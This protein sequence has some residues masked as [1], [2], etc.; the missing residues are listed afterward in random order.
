MSNIFNPQVGTFR[1]IFLYVGQGDATLMIIPD[2]DNHKYVLIDSNKDEKNNGID[3]T[4]LFKNQIPNGELVFINT[5]PHNDHVRG[6][7][8]IK[9]LIGEVWETG[10]EPSKEHDDAKKIINSLSS[11]KNT[12]YLRGT[13][14]INTL[15]ENGTEEGKE[16]HKIGDVDYQIL[17]PSSYVADE[18]NGDDDKIHEQCGVIKFTYKEKSI[19][20][21][22]DSD[23]KA[24]ADHITTYYNDC[25]SADVLSASH[26]GSRSFFKDGE[27]DQNPFKD[28]IE[29]INPK[30][31]IISAPKNSD[32]DHPH[33][34][35]LEI[36]KEYINEE[37]IYN[38][39]EKEQSVV[40]DIDIS[41]KIKINRE[42]L[43]VDSNSG[44]GAKSAEPE[45]LYRPT[46]HSNF[47]PYCQYGSYT[48]S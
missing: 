34:D 18:V 17:S 45:V 12:Y 10:F 28:H 40:V 8:E 7:D 31:L 42:N 20:I 23:K 47:K 35:A 21:T 11:E 37:N 22:G 29:K 14:K 32:H 4:K 26:H 43:D 1:T 36:Y 16:P 5:H 24:W 27:D 38:L 6:A 19:L 41:G 15:S 25:L 39:G 46:S 48:K 3:I 2:G 13:N 9:D 33:D 44:K 30:Y